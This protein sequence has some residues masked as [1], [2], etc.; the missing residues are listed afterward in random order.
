MDGILAHTWICEFFS[1]NSYQLL[2][3]PQ[4]DINK[5]ITMTLANVKKYDIVIFTWTCV[6]STNSNLSTPSAS[7]TS[8]ASLLINY[9]STSTTANFQNLASAKGPNTTGSTS[10]NTYMGQICFQANWNEAATYNDVGIIVVTTNG[11]TA[12][13]TQNVDF[14]VVR[15]SNPGTVAL[16]W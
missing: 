3:D 16:N 7:V 10:T 12:G 2:V 13:V 11:A 15:V 14:Q 4:I 1:Q 5:S 8:N 6:C 9:P